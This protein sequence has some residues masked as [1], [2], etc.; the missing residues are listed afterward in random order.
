MHFYFALIQIDE[1]LLLSLG[2]VHL[3]VFGRSKQELVQ[4]HLHLHHPLPVVRLLVR[5]QH[6]LDCVGLVVFGRRVRDDH[7][8]LFLFSGLGFVDREE[9]SMACKCVISG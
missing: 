7:L 9:T 3:L 1:V 5:P 2:V 8:K 4:T 6:S